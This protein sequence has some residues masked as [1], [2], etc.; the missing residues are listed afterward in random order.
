[1]RVLMIGGGG[2]EHTLVWKIA[3]SPLV[4]QIYCI[5]GNA[6]ISAMADCIKMDVEGAFEPLAQFALEKKMDLTVIGPEDPQ[7]NGIVDY[8]ESLGLK[9]FGPSKAAAE[10]EGSKVFSKELL[11]KYGIPTAEARTFD[12]PE[13]ARSYIQEVGAPI[14]VKADGLAKGKGVI[15]C[16]DVQKALDAV[17]TIM[18]EKAFGDAGNRVLLE[19]FLEGEEA[20]FIAFTDG[21]TILPMASSQDHKPI[22]DGDKGPNTGGMG[23]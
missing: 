21:K 20:S 6:G 5:P 17:N 15:P 9:A 3:Q 10:I 4:E 8:F 16:R 7:A 14:V 11:V 23:A 2:R 12:A 22:Y 1:M 19:E 18:V 13:K